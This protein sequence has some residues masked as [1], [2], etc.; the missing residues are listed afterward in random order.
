MI[1]KQFTITGTSPAA[2]STAAISNPVH[3]LNSFDFFTIDAAVL[4]ATGGTLDLVLQREVGA[5]GSGVW[6]DWCAFPQAAAAA[7][8][9]YYTVASGTDKTITEVGR[10]TTVVLA[11]NTFVGGHPGDA[12]RLIGK[13]GT[14]TSAGAAQTVII[15]A[16][17]AMR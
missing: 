13:A 7:S 2:A 6:A 5:P 4:G 9:K 17:S 10:A 14:S 3:G 1:S 12:V 11:A 8:V 15:N 16:W